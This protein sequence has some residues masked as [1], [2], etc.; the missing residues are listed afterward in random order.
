MFSKEYSLRLN[1]IAGGVEEVRGRRAA[2]PPR[3]PA[4]TEGLGDGLCPE[5]HCHPHLQPQEDAD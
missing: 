3:A 4:R 1:E 2:S 5:G